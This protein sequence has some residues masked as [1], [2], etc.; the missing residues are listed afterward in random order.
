MIY[1]LYDELFSKHVTGEFH[2]ENPKRLNSIYN[3]LKSSGIFE[4]VIK[5][6]SEKINYESLKSVHDPLYIEK[7]EEECR[8]G[9]SLLS[10]GD[11]NI[12]RSSNDVALHAAGGVLKT[13]DNIFNSKINRGFCSVRP[14]G[15]HASADIGM[16]FCLYNNIALAAEHAKLKYNVEKI[17]II[18][19]D[20]HHGNGT[21]DIFYND[22][23]VLFVSTHQHPLYPGTG[24]SEEKGAGSGKGFTIN[25]PMKKGTGNDDIISAFNEIIMPAAK[26]FKPELT[27]IS[28]GFDSRKDDP[29]GGF[30]IDD[31]GFRELTRK[32]IEIS[33]YSGSGKILSILEG[34]YNYEGLSNAVFSHID[35]LIFCS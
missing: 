30:L 3:K 13:L 21:Q 27:L 19:W 18:D 32:V 2:P 26:R 28:A 33:E 20:V 1:F 17:M 5:L 14:P 8:K 25:I 23:S 6:K 29:L 22:N 24:S 15:H 34:G 12:C 4:N 31:D 7:V 35:E 11:T 9:Y 10:T 16:G